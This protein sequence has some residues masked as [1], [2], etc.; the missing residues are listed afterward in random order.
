[1]AFDLIAIGASWGG[2]QALASVLDPLP[3][4]FD[5]PVVVVQHRSPGGEHLLEQV[6]ARSSKLEVVAAHDKDPVLPG[7]VYVAPP[8]YHMLVEPEH[9]ALSTDE[10]VQYARPS[11]DVLFES[12]AD[13]YGRRVVGVLLTGANEDGAEGLARIAAAG[14]FTVVQDPATAARPEMPTA[15]VTRG[16]ARRVLELDRIGPF[17]A[18]LRSG[19]TR[20]EPA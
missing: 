6:L 3:G 18:G 1:M 16:A 13:V 17:L 14:G 12:A 7:R 15:A 8:D 11:I 5:I 4:D 20:G 10:Y 2:M 9:L 19:V